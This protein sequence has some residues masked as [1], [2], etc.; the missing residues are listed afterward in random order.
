MELNFCVRTTID[1]LES[2]LEAKMESHT[3]EQEKNHFKETQNLKLLF[4]GM[5]KNYISSDRLPLP[6]N[7]IEI[8]KPYECQLT[9]LDS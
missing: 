1:L 6:H 2:Y 9:C 5:V 8:S 4:L 7:E 3:P